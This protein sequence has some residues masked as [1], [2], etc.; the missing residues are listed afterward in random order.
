MNG[1]FTVLLKR[2]AHWAL[3][4]TAKIVVVV[5]AQIYPRVTEQRQMLT[6]DD[7]RT[8]HCN[9]YFVIGGIRN[10]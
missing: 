7:P 2:L 6:I 10:C 3:Q 5:V 4:M 8:F 1:S 9:D